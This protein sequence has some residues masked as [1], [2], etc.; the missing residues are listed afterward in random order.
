MERR[1]FQV[2]VAYRSREGKDLPVIYTRLTARTSLTAH[3]AAV[4]ALAQPDVRALGNLLVSLTVSR[5]GA[6]G[7]KG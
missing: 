4:W 3:D 1:A 5:V 2:L 7:V 6:H